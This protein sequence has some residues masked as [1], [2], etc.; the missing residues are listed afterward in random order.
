MGGVDSEIKTGVSKFKKSFGGYMV[1]E[2][3]GLLFKNKWIKI[4]Y[5]IKEYGYI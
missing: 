4:K 2:Y 3:E 5:L 1:K